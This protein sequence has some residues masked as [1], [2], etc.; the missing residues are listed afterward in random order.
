MT[1]QLACL[2]SADTLC[3]R[4][5]VVKPA[6]RAYPSSYANDDAALNAEIET[7]LTTCYNCYQVS[8]TMAP[9]VSDAPHGPA[10]DR[11]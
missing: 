4:T 1:H 9:S 11:H 6:M 10:T 3:F 8:S 7:V 5:F 2:A